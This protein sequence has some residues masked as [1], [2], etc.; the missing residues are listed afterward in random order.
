M[1][2]IS[3]VKYF[4]IINDEACGDI[5]LPKKL[6]K[7]ILFPLAFFFFLYSEGLSCLL[8]KEDEKGMI[9]GLK[10]SRSGPSIFHLIFVDE[11][12]LV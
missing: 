5:P 3:L 9:H 11:G 7:G 4:V 2:G 12:C 8:F 10:A 6:D 1:S